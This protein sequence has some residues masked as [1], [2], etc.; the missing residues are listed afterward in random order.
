MNPNITK[1]AGIN[2]NNAEKKPSAVWN[3]MKL[4]TYH[5]ITMKRQFI[6]LEDVKT[7]INIKHLGRKNNV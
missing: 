1:R 6:Y 4:N 2:K 3:F 5:N 7:A